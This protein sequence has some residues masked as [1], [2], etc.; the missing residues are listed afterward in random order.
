M[1]N[2]L[3]KLMLYNMRDYVKNELSM[4][5]TTRDDFS[6]FEL[7][8]AMAILVGKTKESVMDD[9]LKSIKNKL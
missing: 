7:T 9:Y 2:D 1:E 6:I 5:E 3:Y 8:S 4:K